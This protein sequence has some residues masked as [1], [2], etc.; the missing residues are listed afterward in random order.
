M[1]AE[2]AQEAGLEAK[3]A[4]EA[5]KDLKPEEIDQAV[6]PRRPADDCMFRAS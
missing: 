2:A 1:R 3:E 5:M 4:F 6:P